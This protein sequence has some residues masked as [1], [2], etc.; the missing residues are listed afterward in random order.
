M[1][2]SIVRNPV[3]GRDDPVSICKRCYNGLV[4]IHDNPFVCDRMAAFGS[5]DR[6]LAGE[7]FLVGVGF[8]AFVHRRRNLLARSNLHLRQSGTD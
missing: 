7:R 6:T 8:L 3:S 4:R 1:N 5:I 2:K